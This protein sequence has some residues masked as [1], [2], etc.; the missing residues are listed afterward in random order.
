MG[1]DFTHG[2]AQWAYGL[3]AHFRRRLAEH[4]GFDLE[5]MAGFTRNGRSWDEVTTDLK[6]L[7]NHSD[8]DGALT[9]AE[10]AQVAPRLAEVIATW[11]QDDYDRQSGE[12]LVMAMQYCAEHGEELGF[13]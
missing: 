4:E 12:A 2:D 1:L 13:V 5:A 9:P 6:P 7:L 8:C 11:P 10:C 3:F